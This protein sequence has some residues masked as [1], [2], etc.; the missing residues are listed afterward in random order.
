MSD[1]NTENIQDPE[2]EEKEL[3]SAETE[4]STEAMAEEAEKTDADKLADAEAEILKLKQDILYRVAEFE[5]YRK[6]VLQEKADLIANGGRRVMTA[7]LP[8][9][10]DLERAEAHAVDDSTA[11]EGGE[12]EGLLLILKKLYKVLSDEGLERMEVKGEPFDTDFHEAVTMFPVADE[13]QKGKVYDCVQTGYK[14]NGTVI[15]HAKVVV[16]Q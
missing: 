3:K 6:R 13:D 5:N 8:V 12:D 1:K 16:G 7:L 11:E 2:T 10:D 14:L 4:T 15:R 9:L